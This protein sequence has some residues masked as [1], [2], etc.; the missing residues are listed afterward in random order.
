MIDV[1]CM[2]NV[3]SHSLKAYVAF[4]HVHVQHAD[5]SEQKKKKKNA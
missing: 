4:L 5:V 2:R 3:M 1:N